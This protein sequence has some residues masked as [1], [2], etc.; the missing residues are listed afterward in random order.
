MFIFFSHWS[1]V[2][3]VGQ[4]TMEGRTPI[5]FFV[6]LIHSRS[7]FLT[8]VANLVQLSFAYVSVS[9]DLTISSLRVEIIFMKSDVYPVGIS[10]FSKIPIKC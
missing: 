3:L 2:I 4:V 5:P 7:Y 1:M 10:A 9:I 8:R 6:A